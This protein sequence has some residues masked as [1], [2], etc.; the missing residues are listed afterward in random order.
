MAKDGTN[1]GGARIRSGQKK[2]ALID[3]IAEGNPGKRKLEVIEFKNTAELQG[4]EMPQ[5]RAMLS[6]VQK[7]GKTLVASE[8]YE[9]TW[10]WLEER[11]CAHLVLPQLLERYAMSAAR[12][13]QCEEAIS[14][15]GFLAKHPT[16]GNAIQSP[17]VSMSH[18]FMSQTNRL[19]MEIYQ[20]VREN[21]ATEYSGANPQDDVMERLLTARR[22]K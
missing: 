16:T 6:A 3:K 9:L 21:C 8:I 11:G 1:R 12:W 17:Y 14:E 2:K 19:W 7:D 22:G 5:P 15:F 4:Q 13:I 18:N 20:I 10:K